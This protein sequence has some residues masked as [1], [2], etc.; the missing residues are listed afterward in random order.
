MPIASFGC[1]QRV[2]HERRNRDYVSHNRDL[3]IPPSATADKGHA[4][5][6]KYHIEAL[7]CICPGLFS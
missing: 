3:R 1:L 7:V 2:G 4:V 6:R 5:V